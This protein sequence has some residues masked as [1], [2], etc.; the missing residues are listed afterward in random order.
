MKRAALLLGICA[1]LSIGA[2]Y[3]SNVY[4]DEVWHSNGVPGY[5]YCHDL[6]NLID[7]ECDSGDTLNA[8]TFWS[9]AQRITYTIADD[10][11]ID[12]TSLTVTIGNLVRS[13]EPFNATAYL[14]DENDWT[15]FVANNN[16]IVSARATSTSTNIGTLGEVTLPFMANYTIS[17]TTPIYGFVLQGTVPGAGTWAVPELTVNSGLY[18]NGTP[19]LYD[20]IPR[21]DVTTHS[22]RETYDLWF[23]INADTVTTLTISNPYP[24]EFVGTDPLTVTGTCNDTVGLF[25]SYGDVVSP[26]YED[27]TIYPITC[28][29]KSYSYTVGTLTLGTWDLTASSTGDEV[30]LQFYYGTSTDLWTSNPFENIDGGSGGYWME[31]LLR[32]ATERQNLKPYVYIPQ[33]INALYSGMSGA[34][35]TDWIASV[36]VTIAGTT[37]TIPGITSGLF[38]QIPSGFKTPIRAFSTLVLYAA[39]I[40][41]IWSI[42]TRFV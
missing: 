11:T 38:D 28:S 2:F 40:F 20:F 5:A 9:V 17:S 15:A 7:I 10:E 36:P 8:S 16:A 6:R 39:F 31:W 26:T 12:A 27:Y 30:S 35:S 41:Y 14:L 13:G 24:F 23:K 37:Q 33:I 42:R 4:A 34:T 25:L 21:Y 19:E 1:S 3:V 22:E 32:W 18:P 29:A